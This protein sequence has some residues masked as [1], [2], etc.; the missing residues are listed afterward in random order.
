VDQVIVRS[1]AEIARVLGKETVAEF[2]GSEAAVALLRK[3]GIDYAQGHHIG[4]PAPKVVVAPLRR[5][6]G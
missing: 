2:V 5:A 4:R 6:A 3:L 1:I